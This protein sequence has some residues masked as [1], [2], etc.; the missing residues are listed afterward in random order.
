MPALEFLYL[1]ENAISFMHPMA[2]NLPRLT[3]LNLSFNQ[4]KVPQETLAALRLLPRLREAFLNG[5]PLQ[6]NPQCASF[7]SLTGKMQAQSRACRTGMTSGVLLGVTR[8]TELRAALLPQ[9]EREADHCRVTAEALGARL[10]AALAASPFTPLALLRWQA[11]GRGHPCHLSALHHHSRIKAL[12]MQ[13]GSSDRALAELQR[14]NALARMHWDLMRAAGERAR[15]TGDHTSTERDFSATLIQAAWRGRVGRAAAARER[16][17]RQA[18][19]QQH[20]AAVKIQAAVRGW[21]AR[22]AL[23]AARLA[24]Q[25]PQRVSW[26]D[27]D[28]DDDAALF[29][30]H[31]DLLI[32]FRFDLPSAQPHGEHRPAESAEVLPEELTDAGEHSWDATAL[33]ED[34]AWLDSLPGAG[35][36]SGN[37]LSGTSTSLQG[38]QS[39]AALAVDI[40][41]RMM[42]SPSPPLCSMR[43]MMMDK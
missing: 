14:H 37:E 12:G 6:T 8:Y 11:A 22:R 43:R 40:S 33:P 1:Q 24:M 32:D 41:V 20:G 35:A 17:R 21:R 10:T 13:N 4:L 3:L 26:A 2:S 31:V 42:Q 9:L 19:A 5:N 7:L 38:W 34:V 18:V 29:L 27:D 23:R 15:R 39:P 28:E 16:Q 25:R 30:Q 36:L